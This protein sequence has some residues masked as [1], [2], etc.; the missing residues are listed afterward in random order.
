[1]AVV[2]I[3]PEAV[4]EM[5]QH[6]NASANHLETEYQKHLTRWN[7]TRSVRYSLEQLPIAGGLFDMYF[8]HLEE[9]FTR[10]SAHY[11]NLIH[12]MRDEAQYLDKVSQKEAIV[13]DDLTRQIIGALLGLTPSKAS[14]ATSSANTSQTS[15]QGQLLADQATSIAGFLLPDPLHDKVF[16]IL[17]TVALSKSTFSP[18][19]QSVITS[20]VKSHGWSTTDVECVAFIYMVYG[21]A[22]ISLPLS[23]ATYKGKLTNTLGDADQWWQN[24]NGGPGWTKVPNQGLDSSKLPQKGD[25]LVMQAKL[26]DGTI[27]FGHVAIVTSVD[28]GVVHFAQANSGHPTGSFPINKGAIDASG[29]NYS[30]TTFT[31]QGYFHHSP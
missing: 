25:I 15:P 14:S 22:S 26:A 23:S 1:M 24:F 3:S 20:T 6:L 31:V 29:W 13:R 18:Q 30:T 7:D 4:K 9:R 11:Q 19:V 28:N 16:R 17:D 21:A 27:P 12:Q 5:S 2:Y 10:T 8:D